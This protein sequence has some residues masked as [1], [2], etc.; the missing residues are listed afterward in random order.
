[1]PEPATL[2]IVG[3]AALIAFMRK[4]GETVVQQAQNIAQQACPPGQVEEAVINNAAAGGTTGA[5]AGPYGAAVGAAAGAGLAFASQCGQQAIKDALGRACKKA[6]AVV[7]K[8]RSTG[9]VKIPS[10][11]YGWSCEQRLAFI[12]A[13]VGPGWVMAIG[14][15]GLLVTA[16]VAEKLA[17]EFKRNLKKAEAVLGTVS[18][19]LGIPPPPKFADDILKD[20]A[21]AAQNVVSNATDAV[22]DAA[23]KLNPFGGLAATGAVMHNRMDVDFGYLG[24]FGQLATGSG[25]QARGTFDVNAAVQAGAGLLSSVFGRRTST[26]SAP[27]APATVVVQSGGG[28]GLPSWALPVGLGVAAIGVIALVARK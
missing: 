6:D 10:G 2:L 1:M 20:A 15:G 12:A 16:A 28:S 8:I 3:G 19:R 13:A 18:R 26:V 14:G 23:K 24:N 17:N 22:S 11:Y 4:G 25:T 27:A 21:R 9:L 7:A 5:P